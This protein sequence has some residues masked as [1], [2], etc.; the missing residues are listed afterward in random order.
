MKTLE[1]FWYLYHFHSSKTQ[2]IKRGS[3]GCEIRKKTPIL[4]LRSVHNFLINGFDKA[5]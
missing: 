4:L 2:K 5:D 1:Q 3:G